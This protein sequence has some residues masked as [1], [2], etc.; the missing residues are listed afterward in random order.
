M[1]DGGAIGAA[2]APW[3]GERLGADDVVLSDLRQHTEGFSWETHTVT[4][5]WTQEGIRREQGLAVRVE[6]RDGLNA[7]YDASEQF[8]LHRTLR[9][10]TDIP[11]PDLYW[12]EEDPAV[13][14]TPFYVMERVSGTVPVPWDTSAFARP[15]D[16]RRIG[17]EFA[18]VQARIHQLD[19]RALGLEWLAAGA[20][21]RACAEAELEHW[22]E[23]Y[24]GAVLTE[25]PMLRL[26]IGWLEANLAW[27]E[28]LVLVHGDYRLGNF[29]VDNGHINCILDGEFAHVGAPM[30]DLAFTGLRL[31][32][33][34]SPLVSQLLDRD[35]YLALYQERTGIPVDPDVMRV[36]TVMALLRAAA[37]YVRGCHAF[38]AGRTSDLR[39][40][41]MGH[42]L[43]YLLDEIATEIGVR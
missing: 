24:S 3:L 17:L 7:P 30:Q 19:W 1:S 13:L 34:R 21:A 18:D 20:D 32:R 14:G 10:G 4:A 36:W 29:F 38:E 11:L 41:R 2:L 8:R 39:L 25:V 5:A 28:Q 43:Q 37:V 23:H 16:R 15:E 27:S 26:A 9:D 35:E 42:R 6:P 31:F 40:A 33:G 12:L 22:A